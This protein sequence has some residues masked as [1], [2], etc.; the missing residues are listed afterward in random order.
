MTLPR[1]FAAP[2]QLDDDGSYF[3]NKISLKADIW[4][5]GCILLGLQHNSG[6][7]CG[8]V[9]PERDVGV[10]HMKVLGDVAELWHVP[11]RWVRRERV[12]ARA[13][14]TRSFV[15]AERR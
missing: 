1:S 5:V 11:Q 10:V 9:Y 12:H 14:P 8:S 2:E 4:G 6:Q 7:L 3:D 13:V 15:L